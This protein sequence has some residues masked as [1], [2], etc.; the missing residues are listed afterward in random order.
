VDLNQ[1]KQ[2]EKKNKKDGTNET[3]KYINNG[4][5]KERKDKWKESYE[6]KSKKE[7]TYFCSP[8]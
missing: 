4:I 5:K 1:K 8:Q 3:K 2:R 6:Q 7:R